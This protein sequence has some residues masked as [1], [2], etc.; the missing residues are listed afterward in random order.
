MTITRSGRTPRWIATSLI[1]GLALILNAPCTA[2]DAGLVE[3]RVLQEYDGAS[4]E[5]GEASQVTSHSTVQYSC[6][7]EARRTFLQTPEGVRAV[8][9]AVIV[10]GEGASRWRLTDDASGWWIELREQ[11]DGGI[12]LDHPSAHGFPLFHEKYFSEDRPV[13]WSLVAAGVELASFQSTAQDWNAIDRL[14]QILLADESADSALQEAPPEAMSALLLLSSVARAPD[15]RD[16]NVAEF[17]Q[18]VRAV[19]PLAEQIAPTIVLLYSNDRWRPAQRDAWGGAKPEAEAEIT[20]LSR[21]TS[22]DAV[23]NPIVGIEAP[24]GGGCSTLEQ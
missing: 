21:F 14:A 20:F 4:R 11:T 24:P 10:P 23:R 6:L 3:M 9:E 1:G 19:A 12:K 2:S 15:C 16:T 17:A 7:Q 13:S 22:I 18:L 8:L 5:A